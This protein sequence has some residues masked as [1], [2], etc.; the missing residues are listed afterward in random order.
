VARAKVEVEAKFAVPDRPAFDRLLAVGTLAGFT[1]G[2]QTIQQVTD[3]YLDTPGRA[4]LAAGYAC[5]VRERETGRL[6][7][8]KA[9]P[10]TKDVIQ[11]RQEIETDLDPAAN[12]S[13]IADWPAGPAKELV[14]AAA[15]GGPLRY[16]FTLRQTR[17]VC[18]LLD[19][20]RPVA[21]LS[22]DEV[23]FGTGAPV[24][25]LEVELLPAGT[26]AELEQIAGALEKEWGLSPLSLSKFERGLQIVG[27][28]E[29]VG[30]T[31]LE[32]NKSLSDMPRP[33][34]A[35][36]ERRAKYPD[37]RPDDPMSKAGRKTLRLHFGR[38]LA[39]EPGTRRGEDIEEL[40]DMRV[41]TRRM[42]AAFRVFGPYF[43][44]QAMKP[45]LKGLKRTG[46]ALGPVR[47][48]DVFEEKAQRYL[49][50]LPADQASDLDELLATWHQKREAARERMLAYL[51]SQ[52]YSRFVERFDK[53]LS[54]EGAG[55]RPILAG[56]PTLY[57]VRHVAPRL[58]YNRYEAVRAY[59]PLLDSAPIEL[60][61]ALRIDFK[62]LR[63]ALEFFVPV[64]GT[65]A[66]MVI[67]EVKGMQNHLGGLNDAAMATQ[68][69]RD[70]LENGEKGGIVAYLQNREAE[71]E[72]LLD[73]FPAAWERFDR[74]ELRRNLALAVAVL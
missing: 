70:F 34:P 74:P 6:L 24:L 66:K 57:Q 59:E 72:R 20:E 16:L 13:R 30:L 21:E 7:T 14:E 37:L 67:G 29:G 18:P 28:T 44:P 46:R 69:L 25:E 22:L 73:S 11:Q 48:L 17:H 8:L 35:A 52:R 26:E 33:Y 38:M 42:R 36:S 45:H 54:T 68:L 15:P 4:I 60:L 31:V 63:Y 64:L 39:H 19:G 9:L 12:S 32:H 56:R 62:H 10:T 1:A 61:H 47:D 51:D 41:A 5:R 23:H 43:D 53:F 55:A 49:A 27:A 71:K 2:K 65:E 58:I 40:H 50:T 3:H